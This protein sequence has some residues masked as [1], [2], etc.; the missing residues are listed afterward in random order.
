[1]PVKLSKFII[2]MNYQSQNSKTNLR[3]NYSKQKDNMTNKMKNSFVLIISRQMKKI[4]QRL[5]K[6]VFKKLE[7]K[8]KKIL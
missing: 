2:K 5:T 3:H 6:K 8:L 1:M 7:H 4:P